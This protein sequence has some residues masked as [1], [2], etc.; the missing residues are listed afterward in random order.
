VFTDVAAVGTF[1]S[2]LAGCISAGVAVRVYRRSKSAAQESSSASG[3]SE[4]HRLLE[5]LMDNMATGRLN[6]E[7]T[8][9]L[10]TL[11][12]EL[13][14]SRKSATT[15]GQAKNG[16]ETVPPIRIVDLAT[17]EHFSELA[18]LIA[19]IKP[20][21]QSSESKPEEPEDPEQLTFAL[22]QSNPIFTRRFYSLY[23]VAAESYSARIPAG[24]RDRR[25]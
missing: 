2:A 21:E 20:K 4:E 15:N 16:S 18:R 12:N 14:S 19:K 8:R 17:A 1:L 3:V 9:Q 23:C 25:A 6:P 7:Q 13:S 11:Y 22:N 10:M 24:S 5:H